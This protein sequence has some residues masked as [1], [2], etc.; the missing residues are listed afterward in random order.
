MM[1]TSKFIIN[2]NTENFKRIGRLCVQSSGPV[3]M[4]DAF[5]G[6]RTKLLRKEVL[7]H[8]RQRRHNKIPPFIHL[9]MV[10]YISPVF[11]SYIYCLFSDMRARACVC[12][13]VCV[14]NILI[15]QVR[16]E[17]VMKWTPDPPTPAIFQPVTRISY[18]SYSTHI[19]MPSPIFK[20]NHMALVSHLCAILAQPKNHLVRL[21][22]KETLVRKPN[23]NSCV[24]M[25]LLSVF[26]IVFF[27]FDFC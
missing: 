21:I 26:E 19:T 5:C 1:E 2:F 3:A 11:T 13:C 9:L 25:G 4:Q 17:L 18:T 7:C 27:C 10:S 22:R 6:E 8:R 16:K 15:T 23:K 20:M 24:F 14:F 12:V